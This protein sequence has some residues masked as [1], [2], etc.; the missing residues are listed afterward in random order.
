MN[1]LCP[2]ERRYGRPPTTA[3]HR[4]PPEVSRL[5]VRR[6][7][8]YVAVLQPVAGAVQVDALGMVDQVV[9]HGA[10]DPSGRRPSMSPQLISRPILGPLSGSSPEVLRTQ[11]EGV[12][13]DSGPDLGRQGGA[14]GD[15][16]HH[17]S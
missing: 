5:F 11:R 3:E 8:P 17:I 7:L 9:D 16:Q 15:P 13:H 14:R 2:T 10:G 4:P 1:G 6:H 12:G